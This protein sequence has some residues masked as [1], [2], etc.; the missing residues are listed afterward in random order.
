M[1][2]LALG[3]PA[4]KSD[5]GYLRGRK[6]MLYGAYLAAVAFARAGSGLHHKICHVLGGRYNL[7]HAQTHAVMLPYV[8]AFNSGA[9]PDTVA[10]IASALGTTDAVAGLNALYRELEAPSALKD[11]GLEESNLTEAADRILPHVPGSNP[12]PVTRQNLTNLLR[13]AW[14]GV[15]VP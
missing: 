11:I 6:D 10:R 1:Q 7:P 12:V 15:P 4:V 5:P 14:S 9:V 8:L 3:L 13:A 2:A